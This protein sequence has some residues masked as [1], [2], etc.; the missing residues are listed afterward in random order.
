MAIFVCMCVGDSEYI[1]FRTKK[2]DTYFFMSNI[3]QSGVTL[4]M[5][6]MGPRDVQWI[7]TGIT[8]SLS[9]RCGARVVLLVSRVRLGEYS[10]WVHFI[11]P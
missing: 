6:V 10:P 4:Q 3:V 11:P 9:N 5:I 7:S 8:R 2:P 1:A